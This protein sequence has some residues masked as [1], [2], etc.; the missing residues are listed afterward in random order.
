MSKGVNKILKMCAVVVANSD[1][2]GG[3]QWF[4]KNVPPG[5]LTARNVTSVL[6]FLAKVA[7]SDADEAPR[8]KALL[9]GLLDGKWFLDHLQNCPP[10]KK[11]AFKETLEATRYLDGGQLVDYMNYVRPGEYLPTDNDES[12]VR[13]AQSSLVDADRA[14]VV[15]QI[16]GSGCQEGGF[17]REPFLAALK[18]AS[19]SPDGGFD[20]KIRFPTLEGEL[21]PGATEVRVIKVD[22]GPVLL[23]LR[24]GNPAALKELLEEDKYVNLRESLAGPRD[25]YFEG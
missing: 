5:L 17:Q 25:L 16:E 13:R 11:H 9:E 12:P 21:C 24:A 4:T 18:A 7:A 15:D 14:T 2:E 22:V 23:A 10:H 8:I 6:K 1:P 20:G 19:G 3:A